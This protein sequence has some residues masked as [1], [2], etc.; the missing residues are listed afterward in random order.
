MSSSTL[1]LILFCIFRMSILLHYISF[2]P[3]I[4]FNLS[5]SFFYFQ[6]P[7]FRK[8][9]LEIWGNPK[10]ISKTQDSQDF[11]FW[12]N[13]KTFLNCQEFA[14]IGKQLECSTAASFYG[15]DPDVSISVMFFNA[16]HIRDFRQDVNVSVKADNVD[17]GRNSV[18]K[19]PM[20][21]VQ[22]RDLLYRSEFI[23]LS[24]LNNLFVQENSKGVEGVMIHAGLLPDH[25]SITPQQ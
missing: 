7:L 22:S 23:G 8:I 10:K 18:D 20:H 12:G 9:C 13:C 11:K 1:I 4:N 5:L 15:I 24:H 16:C 19:G 25:L 21:C 2:L 6:F 3:I 14:R 17:N